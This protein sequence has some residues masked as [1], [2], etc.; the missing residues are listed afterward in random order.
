MWKVEK[1]INYEENKNWGD[2]F[3]HLGFHDYFG[4]QYGLDYDNNWVGK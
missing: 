3:S 1:I 2:G 4:N